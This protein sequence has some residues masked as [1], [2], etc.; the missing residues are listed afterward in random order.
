MGTGRRFLALAGTAA[1]A[2]LLPAAG[3]DE[4]VGT[5]DQP[6]IYTVRVSVEPNGGQVRA[7]VD[8]SRAPSLSDDGIL[9]A[10]QSDSGELVGG[11]G[12]AGNDVFV[13]NRQ[14]GAVELISRRFSALDP[15]P[16]GPSFNPSISR[17]GRYVAFESQGQLVPGMPPA[18]RIV[19]RYDRLMNQ[20]R[21]L[22]GAGPPPNADLTNPSISS[23]G[24]WIVLASA[25][26][27]LVAGLTYPPPGGAQIYVAD[28]QPASPVFTLI[29]RSSVSATTAGDAPS[30]SPRIRPD[31]GTIVFDSSATNLGGGFAVLSDVFAVDFDTGTSAASPPE[32]CSVNTAGSAG[33]DPSFGCAVSGDGN[34]VAFATQAA[35]IVPGTLDVFPAIAL[36]DRAAGTTTPVGLD[37]TGTAIF[38]AVRP[39]IS[40]DG[41]MIA[42]EALSQGLFGGPAQVWVRNLASGVSR[43]ASV[44][45]RGERADINAVLP[46]LSGQGRVVAWESRATNLV[47]DDTNGA[48]DIFVRTPLR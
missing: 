20:M 1:M 5:G 18:Q 36:R 4:D 25:A 19:Y 7:I 22:S 16:L 28:M 40:D 33:A 47:P 26:T 34:L 46:A 14:T 38:N 3:C 8:G 27:N 30:G 45:I 42:W 2:A 35:N 11:D 17:D 32:I 24:R 43:V 44:N 31:G 21:A 37:E 9:V 23:D 10:F 13:K 48:S 6:G 39:A 12:F 29:S 15:T 41:T